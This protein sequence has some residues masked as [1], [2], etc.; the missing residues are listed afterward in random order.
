MIHESFP[1]S[2]E[3]TGRSEAHRQAR[4]GAHDRLLEHEQSAEMLSQDACS[5]SLPTLH[6]VKHFNRMVET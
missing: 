2:G 4:C 1:A 3:R 6:V 5:V